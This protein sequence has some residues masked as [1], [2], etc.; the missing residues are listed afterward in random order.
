MF[1]KY[2]EVYAY[3]TRWSTIEL[4]YTQIILDIRMLNN[5]FPLHT[6]MRNYHLKFPIWLHLMSKCKYSFIEK[7]KLMLMNSVMLAIS[8]S[9]MLRPLII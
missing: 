8:E 2:Y 7:K 3:V 4:K 6:K 5:I 1:I 9:D